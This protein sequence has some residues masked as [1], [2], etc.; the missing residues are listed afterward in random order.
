MGKPLAFCLVTVLAITFSSVAE[1]QRGGTMSGGARAAAPARSTGTPRSGHV[2]TNVRLTGT[3]SPTRKPSNFSSSSRFYRSNSSALTPNSLPA[4]GGLGFDCENLG[5]LSGSNLGVE[6]LI[7]PAT[8]ANLALA[9]RFHRFGNLTG[10]YLLTGY[11]GGYPIAYDEPQADNQEE[12]PA[13]QQPPQI[14][15]IQHPMAPARP[16]EA[17]SA[18]AAEAPLPDV[19]EFTLILKN[20]NQISAVAFTRHND[21]LVYITRE[22]NRRTVKVADVD[23]AATTKLNEDRGTPLK[24]SI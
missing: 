10:A 18:P 22:G 3:P 9:A 23:A 4:L 20:G 21:Q 2:F 24:L 17:E 5:C 11:G 1:A 16:A 14:I 7:N 8:Q 6:A 12:E 19:G 13:P 15:V